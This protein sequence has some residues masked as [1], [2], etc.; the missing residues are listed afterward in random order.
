MYLDCRHL[1]SDYFIHHFPNIYKKCEN[2]GFNITICRI[3][4][5]S[6]THYACGGITIKESGEIFIHNLYV[7][8]ECTHSSL[9]GD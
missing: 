7:R 8:G 2:V 6:A 9:H 1:D 4:V 3:P 5:V